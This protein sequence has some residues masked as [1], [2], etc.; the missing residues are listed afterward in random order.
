M[1]ETGERDPLGRSLA[2]DDEA[3]WNVS[4]E[5]E[6]E[7]DEEE[8]D[9]DSAGVDQ[10]AEGT[11]GKNRG[12]WVAREVELEDGMRD[13]GFWIEGR[14]AKVRVENRGRYKLEP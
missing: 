6:E 1:W 14:E 12:R 5:E 11:R 10:S 3:R 9:E 7:D 2:K 4:S 8:L 13:V